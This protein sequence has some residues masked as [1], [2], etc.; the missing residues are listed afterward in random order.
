MRVI[1]VLFFL[2]WSQQ[3]FAQAILQKGYIIFTNGKKQECLIQNNNWV[4]MPNSISYKL[5]EENQLITKDINLIQEFEIYN[6]SWK[7]FVAEV[8]I[9]QTG[10]PNK[11]EKKMLKC[12]LLG[13][14][15]LYT[16]LVNE[17]KQFFF[18]TK[19]SK[20][21]QL[22]YREVTKN[23]KIF[24]Y[25]YY[26]QQLLN[27]F[28]CPDIINFKVISYSAS[29]LL[30]AFKKYNDYK[31]SEYL[32]YTKFKPKN[33]INTS[34]FGGRSLFSINDK[35]ID[36]SSKDVLAL[37]ANNIFTIGV[38]FEYAFSFD[39]GKWALYSELQYGYYKC[40]GSLLERTGASPSNPGGYGLQIIPFSCD[41]SVL[42]IP[43]GLRYY[44]FINSNHKIFC[45][46]AL[47]Y[48]MLLS[49]NKNISFDSAGKKEYIRNSQ[50]ESNLG[51]H[52]GIGYNYRSKYGVEIRYICGNKIKIRNFG[53]NCTC[54][55]LLFRYKF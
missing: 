29:S 33:T 25:E 14:A 35:N 53:R 36:S 30:R 10:K 17:E 50:I 11:I 4:K 22:V 34:L 1:F 6:T 40:E 16:A 27:S 45:N 13:E 19:E 42:R 5:S 32:N 18:K 7:C 51:F 3:I 43:V 47:S 28:K 44:S 26:K 20:I 37:D 48:G 9:P 15:S 55:Q 52:L 23:D 8:E 2:I 41:F 38:D 49:D 46:V 24:A 21:V 54:L 12:L 31:K 39:R